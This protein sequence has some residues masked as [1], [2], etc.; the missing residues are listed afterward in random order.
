MRERTATSGS[1]ER[2]ELFVQRVDRLLEH[3]TMS[4]DGGALQ[5]GGGP[6]A[7]QFESAPPR[8]CRLLL[9]RQRLALGSTARRLFLLELDHLRLE[10]SCHRVTPRPSRPVPRSS[11]SILDPRSSSSHLIP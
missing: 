7:R 11:S 1:R 10:P 5:I 8:E 9:S 4:R 3:L 6:R 2:A